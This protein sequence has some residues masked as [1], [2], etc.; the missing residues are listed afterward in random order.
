MR[1]ARSARKPSSVRSRTRRKTPTNLSLRTDLVRRARALEL[2]ISEV[3]EAALE[4][5]IREL[6]LAEWTEANQAAIAG[7]NAFIAEHGLFGDD[8]RLF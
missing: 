6:E 4:A 1:K 3:V 5:A 8:Q 7:Y 2:N